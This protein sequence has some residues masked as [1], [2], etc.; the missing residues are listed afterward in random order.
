MYIIL[1]F[2]GSLATILGIAQLAFL[3]IEWLGIVGA[4]IAAVLAI[5]AAASRSFNYQERYLNARL[6]AEKLR[7]QYFLFLG[8]FSPYENDQDRAEKLLNYVAD[9][10]TEGVK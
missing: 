10:R 7:G 1:I 4:L 5:A 6:A 9:V 2:G 8:H 3:N